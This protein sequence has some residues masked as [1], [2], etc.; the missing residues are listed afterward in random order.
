MLIKNIH[1]LNLC[2]STKDVIDLGSV[3][4]LNLCGCK[5]NL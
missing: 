4:K 5:N 1:T 3:Y 2:N